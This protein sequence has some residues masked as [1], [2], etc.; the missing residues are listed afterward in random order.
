LFFS[1]VNETSNFSTDF[2][3]IINCRIH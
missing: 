1:D 2:G 3:T